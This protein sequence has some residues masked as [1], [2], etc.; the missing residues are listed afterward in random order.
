MT[1]GRQ[2]AVVIFCCV[3]FIACL[4]VCA[5]CASWYSAGLQVEVYH[6][7]GIEISQWEVWNGA[8]PP[9]RIIHLK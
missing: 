5:G 6:R 4:F 7:N 3:F 2:L 1:E 8:K 9:E